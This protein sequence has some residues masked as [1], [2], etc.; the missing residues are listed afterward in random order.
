MKGGTRP[1]PNHPI[2]V[3]PADERVTV[4]IGD[5]ILAKS[6][7]ALILREASLPPVF[8]IPRAD[9][10]ME[11]L[12][13]SLTQTHCPYKGDAS[14]FSVDDGGVKDVAC[15]YEKPFDHMSIIKGHLAFYP[16][17]VDAIEV[18]DRD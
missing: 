10:A 13:P 9:V 16:D 11:T 12:S 3:A 18:T 7:N 4:R 2:T 1:S 6:E 8:Y 14:H 17:R 5:T 15:S